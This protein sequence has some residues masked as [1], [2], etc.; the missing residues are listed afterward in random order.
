MAFCNSCGTPLIEG[1][2]FC[3]RCG[4]ATNHSQP[5]MYEEFA[6]LLG[7]GGKHFVITADSLIYGNDEYTYEQLSNINLRSAPTALTNGVAQTTI[8][9]KTLTLSYA[10]NQKERF[11]AAMTYA[12]EQI[13]IAHGKVKNCKYILQTSTGS[14][15]EVYEDYLILYYMATNSSGIVGKAGE[16][17][18]SM[19]KGLGKLINSLGSVGTALEAN[20]QRTAGFMSLVPNLVGGGFGIKGAIKGIA[21]AT[22]FNLVRDDIENSAI[23]KVANINTEQQREVYERINPKILMEN[24]FTDYWRL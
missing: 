22:A 14:K 18:S 10:V 23:K 4:N 6:S 12:N 2:A 5:L 20:Q 17:V 3:T 19:N 15:I 11:A 7:V 24:V 21:G 1:A 16:K 13:D 9:G 8:N